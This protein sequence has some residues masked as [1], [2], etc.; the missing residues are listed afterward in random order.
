M[1][2]VMIAGIIAIPFTGNAME[3]PGKHFSLQLDTPMAYS[4][5]KGVLEFTLFTEAMNDTI[6]VF[7]FKQRSVGDNL[8]LKS[9]GNFGNYQNYG[10]IFNFGL[11]NRI[12]L[13]VKLEFPKIDYGI[14]DLDITRLNAGLKW[15]F[16]EENNVLPALA[17]GA[18]Y[19]NDR[20]DNI[21]RRFSSITINAEGTELNFNFTNP[22]TITISGVKD[23]TF[24]VNLYA[25]KYLF[26]DFAVH[27]FAGYG[28]TNVT[29]DFST[30]LK[31][32][33]VQNLLKNLE[34][35]EDDFTIGFGFHYKITD[36]IV[37][38]GNYR[39]VYLDRD[40]DSEI[41]D[42]EKRNDIVDVKLN[43]ILGKYISMTLDGKYLRHNFVGEIPFIYNKFTAKQSSHEY[44]YAGVGFTVHY[45]YTDLFE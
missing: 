24:M 13:S 38:N 35:D 2:L 7:D 41:S 43:F 45:D 29:S 4:L 1:V 19:R 44:G 10:G 20:G 25:S 27:T 36:W 42:G 33:K 3:P 16:L 26:N 40:I 5:G 17:I 30:S 9:L 37:L 23:E 39:F 6:D 28:K 31:I 18:G 14:D 34:Y 15:T 32:D 12:M 8:D 21:K 11:T 22:Q